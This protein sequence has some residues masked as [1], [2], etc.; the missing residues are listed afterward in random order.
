M[1][2]EVE[3]IILED[4]RVRSCAATAMMTGRVL[5]R[6]PLSEEESLELYLALMREVEEHDA[7]LALGYSQQE[8]QAVQEILDAQVRAPEVRRSSVTDAACASPAGTRRTRGPARV[9]STAVA[10]NG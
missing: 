5:S 10:A 6:Q 2:I 8:E 7:E 4:V 3:R 1:D 9:S